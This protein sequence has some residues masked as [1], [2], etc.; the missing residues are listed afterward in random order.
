[1]ISKHI[2]TSR[3]NN[4]QS[5]FSLI[6]LMV[7][8][9]VSVILITVGIPSF[10]SFFESTRLT[11]E[12]NNLIIAM[13]LARSEAVKRGEAVTVE[14]EVTA[15]G[16]N[17]GYKVVY[18]DPLTPLQVWASVPNSIT[19]GTEIDEVSFSA[20]GTVLLFKGGNSA[21]ISSIISL[22][23]KSC[24]ANEDNRRELKFS[25]T[26]KVRVVRKVCEA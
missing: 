24:V 11:T 23:P 4:H 13:N 16:W 2:Q 10:A 14:L 26:G 9:V 22:Q 25:N 19:M 15:N 20:D 7:T 21:P 6:E 3:N 12:S 1:M 18:D 17:G 5:G 8:I